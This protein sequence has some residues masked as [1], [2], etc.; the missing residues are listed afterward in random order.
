MIEYPGFAQLEKQAVLKGY[1][2]QVGFDRFEPAS[3]FRPAQ[4]P[5]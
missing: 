5:T 1:D 2:V 3:S 4:H